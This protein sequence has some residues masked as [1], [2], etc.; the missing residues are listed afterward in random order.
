MLGSAGRGHGHVGALLTRGVHGFA[1]RQFY[2]RRV[3]NRA[4]LGS[5]VVRVG[6]GT[7]TGP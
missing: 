4:I 3:N 5:I 2:A 1:I 6:E 7:S